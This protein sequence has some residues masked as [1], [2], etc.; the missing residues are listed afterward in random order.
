MQRRAT[1]PA[2]TRPGGFLARW[3][4][5]TLCA[6]AAVAINATTARAQD[7]LPGRVGRVADVG[8]EMFLAPQDQPEQWAPIG[9]NYPVT[10]GDNLWVG[11]EGRAEVDFGGGQFRMAGNTSVHVSR[12]DDRQ[13][14]LFVAQGSVQVRVRV[15]DP[16]ETARID[17]PNAQVVLLRP[18]SYRIDVSEDRSQS[19]VVVREGE[20]NVL[21]LASVQ[22]VLPGQTASVDGADPQFATVR[23][24]YRNDDF[25]LW[26][27]SRDRRYER[28]RSA[29][30][31]SPQM[32]G[33]AEL[34]EYGTWTQMP[35]YGA[36]WYPS[37]VAP[38]WAPYR[39]GYWAEV[40]AWGPTWVD[41]A[42]WGYAPFHYG[43][44]AYIGGRWGWCPG[45]YVAR[46]LWAPALVGWAGGPG[47]GLSVSLGAPVY[48]WVPL[49][50]G[51]P[52][53]P[54]WNRCSHGCWDRYNR[55][56]NVNTATV[57]PNSPPPSRYVN[58]NAPGGI[59]A[60]R[61]VSLT[62]R[63]PVQG[64][65]V[66]VPRG[67]ASSAP[68]LAGAPMVRS[69]P[70]RIPTRRAGDGTP[71]PASTFYPTLARPSMAPGGV[72]ALPRSTPSAATPGAPLTRS[73]TPSPSSVSP[74]APGMPLPRSGTP[75]PTSTAPLVRQ[76]PST[77][78][79][80]S[81]A[82]GGGTTS[83]PPTRPLAQQGTTSPPPAVPGA[84]PTTRSEPRAAPRPGMASP[85]PAQPQQ[86]YVPPSS[87][88]MQRPSTRPQPSPVPMAVAPTPMPS[89]P[90]VRSAPQSQAP[91]V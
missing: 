14:A 33:A 16:G 66:D 53:R 90:I 8:G 40:G 4:V 77:V 31:V 51:E 24:G 52:F 79:P 89:A 5:L 72:G 61:G 84:A 28:G 91:V 1:L 81:G 17:T 37:A 71:P 82:Y 85:M 42:P 69:E 47:W 38:D 73:A 26:A 20:V 80:S 9:L 15:L 36:V 63:R 78:A 41:A 60:V 44:W 64:N 54:W 6:M 32:V 48:G 27:G 74:L 76:A 35:E 70:G 39:N 11:N 56:Y 59:S 13:F 29:N 46:P 68:V 21:T 25:D 23:N 58:W 88:G 50:W 45:A 22:Q 57:R 87:S 19:Q 55:P 12:L 30:Y 7:D 34:D 43:R 83:A 10:S 18:G 67:I 62:D 49:G 65:L 2:R 3:A 75:P 86:A